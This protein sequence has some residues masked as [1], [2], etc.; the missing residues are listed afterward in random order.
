VDRVVAGAAIDGTDGGAVVDE[1][2]VVAVPG[3]ERVRT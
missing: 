2:D 1:H 3:V